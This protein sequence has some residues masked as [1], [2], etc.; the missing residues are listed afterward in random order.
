[1]SL[2][3]PDKRVMYI[4]HPTRL[5]HRGESFCRH[6]FG[7]GYAPLNPFNCGPFEYFEGGILGRENSLKFG[8]AIQQALC[9][10][11]G[12]YGISEGVMGEIQNR[13]EWDQDKRI[14]VFHDF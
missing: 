14:R 8:L 1:M 6:A 5:R 2:Y 7:L 11:T 3:V 9:G 13:L 12:V 4:A 10:T